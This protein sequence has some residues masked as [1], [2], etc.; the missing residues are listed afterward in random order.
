MAVL[1]P[2]R[3]RERQRKSLS[4]DAKIGQRSELSSQGAFM[5]DTGNSEYETRIDSDFRPRDCHPS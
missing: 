4:V 1:I 5:A 3:K 2:V